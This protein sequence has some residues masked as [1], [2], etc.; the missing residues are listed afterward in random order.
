MNL[1]TYLYCHLAR[2]PL[3]QR[4]PLPARFNE[5]SRESAEVP[6]VGLFCGVPFLIPEKHFCEDEER[7]EEEGRDFERSCF[8]PIRGLHVHWLARTIPPACGKA[9]DVPG[10]E[11]ERRE[12]RWETSPFVLRLKGI[13]L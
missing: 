10:A 5:S 12:G 6:V 9:S 4:P 3:C 8:V 1:N 2:K 11:D 7:L 13:L